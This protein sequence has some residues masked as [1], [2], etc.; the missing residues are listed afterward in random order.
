MNQSIAGLLKNRLFLGSSKKHSDQESNNEEL[1]AGSYKLGDKNFSGECLSNLQEPLQ[2]VALGSIQEELPTVL[3]AGHKESHSTHARKGKLRKLKNRVKSLPDL[4]HEAGSSA[5]QPGRRTSDSDPGARSRKTNHNNLRRLTQKTRSLF[6]SSSGGQNTQSSAIDSIPQISIIS[7]SPASDYDELSAHAQRSISERRLS[8]HSMSNVTRVTTGSS[9]SSSLKRLSFPRRPTI[10]RSKSDIMVPPNKASHPTPNSKENP[11]DNNIASPVKKSPVSRRRSKTVG[12][13]DYS[14][15]KKSVL[16]NVALQTGRVRSN[17]SSVPLSPVY[18]PSDS[19]SVQ[20]LPPNSVGNQSQLNTPRLSS[21]SSFKRSSSIVNAISNLVTLRSSNTYNKSLPPVP[22][23]ESMPLPP[24]PLESDS[25]DQYLKKLGKYG[26]YI[27]VILSKDEDEF[28]LQC[29]HKFISE[30]FEFRQKPLDISLR[31]LL[32]FIDLPKETQQID[33]VLIEFSKTYYNENKENS[34]WESFDQVYFITFSL[35]ILHTDFFNVKNKTKITKNEFVKLIRSDTDSG[36]EKLPKEVLEY[37]YDNITSIEFPRFN[38]PLMYDEQALQDE[39]EVQD[40]EFI[41]SPKS[42]TKSLCLLRLPEFSVPKP[43]HRYSSN[44]ISSYFSIGISNSTSSSASSVSIVNDDV[45][46]YFHIANDSL[47]LVNLGHEIDKHC[48]LKIR[49]EETNFRKH[50]YPKYMSVLK[51]IKGGYLRVHK[52]YVDKLVQT[53]FELSG[54]GKNESEYRF[55]KIVHMGEFEKLI[56]SKKFSIVGNVH[57]LVWR[58]YFGI[59]TT[60]NLFIFDSMDWADPKIEIDEYTNTSNY[61][62][63]YQ[64]DIEIVSSIGCNGLF[65]TDDLKLRQL[66]YVPSL[67]HDQD[68][69]SLIYLYGKNQMDVLKCLTEYDKNSWIDSINL[70][71][72]LDGCCLNKGTIP[73]SLLTLRKVTPCERLE[74]LDKTKNEKLERLHEVDSCINFCRCSIPLTTKTRS[75]LLDFVKQLTTKVEWL[76]YEI[77]R[78]KVYMNIIKEAGI[79]YDNPSANNGLVSDDFGSIDESFLFNDTLQRC[80]TERSTLNDA[81]TTLNMDGLLETF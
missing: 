20:F 10:I 75:N 15:H 64:P 65:A 76:L 19:S 49:T 4:N 35:L 22:N 7:T 16:M 5:E 59:L 53:N 24:R 72:A 42:M 30:Y 52:D 6:H 55:I 41:Y 26:K 31:E 71:A 48:K 54:I 47:S 74:R 29:L 45:D 37:F 69:E 32:L 33:R 40:E 81:D 78:N 34:I 61:I 39:D 14:T 12:A 17:S 3:E 2:T 18:L 51:E 57:R 25:C 23:L 21:S 36:G 11:S 68:N 70:V 80:Y 43:S 77:R 73:Y 50:Y 9:T 63:D 67:E 44:T 66:D 79:L 56:N 62:I 60:C 28:K 1:S 38:I 8:S 58:K 27:G 13:T 46:P